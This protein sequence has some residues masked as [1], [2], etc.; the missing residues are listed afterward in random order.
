MMRKQGEQARSTY[1]CPQCQP[2][3]GDGPAPVGNTT[4]LRRT[5]TGC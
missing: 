3:L 5:R 2:W 1:W 4:R